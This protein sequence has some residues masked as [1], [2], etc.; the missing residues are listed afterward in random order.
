MKKNLKLFSFLLAVTIGSSTLIACNSGNSSTSNDDDF[1]LSAMVKLHT[2]EV[3]DKRILDILE[4]KSGVNLDIE[5]VPAT[6]YVEKV[7]TAFASGTFPHSIVLDL[8]L[9]TQYKQY[10]KDG[11]FWEIGPYLDEFENLSK[12]REDILE[13]TMVDGKVYMLYE[14]KPLS[15]QGI[16]YRQDWADNLGLEAPTNIDEFYEM[17]RAFTEDD[18]DGNGLDDTFGLSDRNELTFGAFKT[19]ASWFHTPN[20]FGIQDGQILPDFMFPEYMDTLDFFRDIH[21][22]GYMNQDFPVTSKNDQRSLFTSGRAGVY[23]GSMGDVQSFHPNTVANDSNAVL[24]VHNQ[25]EG[26]S[27]E[28]TTWSLPGYGNVILFPKS[29]IENEEELRKVLSFYDFLMTP[30]GANLVYWGIEGEHYE[31]IDDNKAE[32]IDSDLYNKEV[33]P[34]QTLE[35]AEEE[36]SGRYEAHFTFEAR[37]K[38]EELY[39]DNENYLIDDP[40]IGLESET[41]LSQSA[42]LQ[43][44]IEDATYQYIIG[45]I[46][47][48]GFQAAIENWLNRGGQDIIDEFTASYKENN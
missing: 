10:I 45:D 18:P 6:T 9:L 37:A 21:E 12:M 48:E 19:V 14:G 26:P 4:E 28:F 36:S 32:V 38:A 11:Q 8:D 3:P 29:S 13:N 44:I 1:T 35:I 31:V 7:N 47:K 30:E 20:N 39:A 16:I 23:V 15:R 2:P 41:F 43:R 27:G 46:D 42:V 17:L 22:K 34:I 40:T 25:V 24:D 5:F 33:F